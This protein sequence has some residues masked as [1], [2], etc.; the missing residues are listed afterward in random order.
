MVKQ[1]H[2]CS[3]GCYAATWSHPGT[4]LP[5]PHLGSNCL[6]V[7][8]DVLSL[9]TAVAEAAVQ[10]GPAATAEHG[11]VG[12]AL[13]AAAATAG[14]PTTSTGTAVNTV[15]GKGLLPPGAA[16]AAKGPGLATMASSTSAT[17][18]PSAAAAAGG[19]TADL[20]R[21]SMGSMAG[22]L[23]GSSASGLFPSPVQQQGVDG[24]LPQAVVDYL[25][26]PQALSPDIDSQVQA[27][28]TVVTLVVALVGW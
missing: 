10:P 1:C 4:T 25:M 6:Q 3:T 17:A 15:T 22:S 2:C 20:G 12:A 23:N 8:G 18:S 19:G 24:V 5:P 21:S 26:P 11:T 9:T 27:V 7:T 16:Q 13:A 28:L 14:N